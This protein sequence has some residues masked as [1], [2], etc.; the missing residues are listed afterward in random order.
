M[1][2]LNEIKSN[3]SDVNFIAIT[4]QDK[5]QVSKFLERKDF[6]FTHLIDAK[7][8]LNSFGLFG[9][10]KTLILDKNMV[11][12]DIEK[13]IPKDPS[14][15]KKNTENFKNRIINTISELKQR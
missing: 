15:N 9:Y 11:I 6:H 2:I 14:N 3:L 1:P 4:F 8:Y 7:D 12:V 13:M 10:P 5:N